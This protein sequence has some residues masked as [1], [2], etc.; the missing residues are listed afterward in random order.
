MYRQEE[1]FGIGMH[2]NPPDRVRNEDESS[3]QSSDEAEAEQTSNGGG[4]NAKQT[5]AGAASQK[6][7]G[8]AANAVLARG[9]A[10]DA[11]AGASAQA[12]Q[13]K[14][15]LAATNSNDETE[16]DT[17]DRVARAY[18]L[19][20]LPVYDAAP[21]FRHLY[22][23]GDKCRHPVLSYVNS[24]RAGEARSNVRLYDVYVNGVPFRA[25]VARTGIPQGREILLEYGESYWQDFFAG[26]GVQ[27]EAG[28]G[29]A[30]AEQASSDDDVVVT[31][32]SRVEDED[33]DEDVVVIE[34]DDAN[35]EAA[36]EADEADDADDAAADD[37][38]NDEAD[39]ADDEQ[40]EG[41]DGASSRQWS[42]RRTVG[43]FARGFYGEDRQAD[44]G[45]GA[46]GGGR[47]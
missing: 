43:R 19:D 20:L 2:A 39:D 23:S 42:F 27:A 7:A 3:D 44:M 37:D 45:R 47:G 11:G 15:V 4:A 25:V 12:K 8:A 40:D 18:D 41:S 36:D 17:S 14:E 21:D 31:G 34:A 35:D 38:G 46:E 30:P 33:D 1:E 22:L 28:K 26:G 13:A 6:G 9:Q 29:V 32:V 5:G 24:A 16:S 10:E